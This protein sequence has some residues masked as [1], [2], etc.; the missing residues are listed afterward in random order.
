MMIDYVYLTYSI[1]LCAYALWMIVRD[2]RTRMWLEDD[3]VSE[4]IKTEDVVSSY[5]NS[6]SDRLCGSMR[7]SVVEIW[8]SRERKRSRLGRAD[9]A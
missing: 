9:H 1:V 6:L 4:M 5:I 7:S 3:E 2:Y 8:R